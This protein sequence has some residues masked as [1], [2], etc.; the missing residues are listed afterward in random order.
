L[1]RAIQADASPSMRRFSPGTRRSGMISISKGQRVCASPSQRVRTQE[2]GPYPS[3]RGKR[4]EWHRAAS[5]IETY[6]WEFGVSDQRLALENGCAPQFD[7]QLPVSLRTA[8][9]VSDVVI[10]L[11]EGA[12][13]E[14]RSA[15]YM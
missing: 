11:E 4:R 8:R 10:R 15:F 9:A 1:R 2:L 3:R 6:R 14:P 5:R 7:G 13:V 12:P